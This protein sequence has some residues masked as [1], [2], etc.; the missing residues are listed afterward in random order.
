M[1]RSVGYGLCVAVVVAGVVG[2]QQTGFVRTV[3]QD[4]ELSVTDRHGVTTRAE[5]DP[6]ISSGRH[7]HPGEELGYVAEGSAFQVLID[8]KPPQMLKAGDVFF[9]PANTV[10]GGKNVGTD[11]VKVIGTY[12]IEK[13][14]PLSSPAK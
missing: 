13:G 12:F 11:K 9:V 5:I 6:G 7:T 10:H 1:R 2:A 8:G 14:K 4:Q 3:L